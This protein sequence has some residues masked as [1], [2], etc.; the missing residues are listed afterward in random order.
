M[1]NRI[2]TR[3]DENKKIVF[4]YMFL[5][6][7]LKEEVVRIKVNILYNDF[8]KSGDS[9]FFLMGDCMHFQYA[10]VNDSDQYA[11]YK[12]LFN[13]RDVINQ[14]ENSKIYYTKHMIGI[15]FKSTK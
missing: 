10:T 12:K 13:K 2:I 9:A 1:K 6:S 8:L 7:I 5:P 11:F 15:K 4:Q 3:I 14:L